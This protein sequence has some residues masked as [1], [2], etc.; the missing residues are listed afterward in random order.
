MQR[1]T[2]TAYIHDLVRTA[3]DAAFFCQAIAASLRYP[4]VDGQREALSK[5]ADIAAVLT[6]TTESQLSAALNSQELAPTEAAE[7]SLKKT[8]RRS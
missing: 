3:S 1:F 7:N 5:V 8:D 4:L 2:D 6:K